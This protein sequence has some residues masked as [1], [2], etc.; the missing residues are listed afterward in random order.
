MVIFWKRIESNRMTRTI[1]WIQAIITASTGRMKGD[2]APGEELNVLLCSIVKSFRGQA[3]G[4]TFTVNLHN[5]KQWR[6][7]DWCR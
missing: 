5:T 1:Q 3:H 4:V 6:T 2:R 7:G